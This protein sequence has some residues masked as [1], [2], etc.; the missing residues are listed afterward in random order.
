MGGGRLPVPLQGLREPHGGA[1]AEMGEG[2]DTLGPPLAAECIVHKGK[3][4][5]H[6]ADCIL[7]PALSRRCPL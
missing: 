7:G 2:I 6:C 5:N 3:A 4:P 1:G